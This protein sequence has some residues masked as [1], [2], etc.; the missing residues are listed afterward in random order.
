MHRVVVC[1]QSDFFRGTLFHPCKESINSTVDLP[2][3]D[4]EIVQRMVQFFYKADYSDFPSDHFLK[5]AQV[6]SVA[7]KYGI[8]KLCDLSR[9][10]YWNMC[11][12]NWDA[13]LFL[14]SIPYI[15]ESTHESVRGL[16]DT[17]RQFT[18]IH[19]KDITESEVLYETWKH[20]CLS[21]PL[22]AFDLIQSFSASPVLG[23]C[24]DCGPMQKLE[25]LQL[26]CSRCGKGGAMQEHG[27]IS[28]GRCHLA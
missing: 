2:E 28:A 7:T 12:K 20:V 14:E 4:A 3:E 16:R 8:S 13:A 21:V 25:S 27:T 19:V 26:R 6:F 22:F 11:M 5:N 18:R 23:K 1:H 10:K 24:Y 17:V 9:S 15:H